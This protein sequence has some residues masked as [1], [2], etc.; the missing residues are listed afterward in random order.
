MATLRLRDFAG[1]VQLL[2]PTQLGAAGHTLVVDR[3]GWDTVMFLLLFGAASTT[4]GLAAKMTPK[5]KVAESLAGPWVDAAADK[6]DYPMPEMDADAKLGP[7]AIEYT[8]ASRFLRVDWTDW[9]GTG[10]TIDTAVVAMRGGPR[11]SLLGDMAL[12]QASA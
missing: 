3:A 4:L 5:I 2:T 11:K 9:V 1:P 10:W 12:G 7:Y 8:G 6:L